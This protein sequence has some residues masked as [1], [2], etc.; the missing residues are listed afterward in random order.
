MPRISLPI[1][2]RFWPKVKKSDGCWTW[3][4]S[5]SPGGYGRFRVGGRAEGTNRYAHRVALELLGIDLPDGYHVD[6]LCENKRCVNPDH[7]D[8]VTPRTNVRRSSWKRAA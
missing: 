4:G 3:T 2:D 7:L 6:H 5:I 1:A 8:V